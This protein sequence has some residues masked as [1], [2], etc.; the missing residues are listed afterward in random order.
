[1]CNCFAEKLVLITNHIKPELPEKYTDLNID[2]EG[3]SFFMDGKPHVPVN[4]KVRIEYRGFKRNGDP[5]VNL[6]KDSVSMM[7]RYCPFCGEDTKA[8]ENPPKFNSSDLWE[9]KSQGFIGYVVGLD[10]DDGAT[11]YMNLLNAEGDDVGDTYVLVDLSCLT[12]VE[13]KTELQNKY[14]KLLVLIGERDELVDEV[15]SYGESNPTSSPQCVI[16]LVDKLKQGIE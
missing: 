4:P 11:G 8:A 10:I 1:M 9:W 2:W 13:K 16:D 7:A 3:Y 5:K 14:D 12:K 6:T 15:C